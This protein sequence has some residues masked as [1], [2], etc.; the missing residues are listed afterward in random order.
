MECRGRNRS[1]GICGWAKVRIYRLANFDV[2]QS[3]AI[4]LWEEGSFRSLLAL[5][6]V[7]IF[8]Y[9]H[10]LENILCA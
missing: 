6:M 10:I 9:F 7:M 4:D 2:V 1:R 3:S 5:G 8:L